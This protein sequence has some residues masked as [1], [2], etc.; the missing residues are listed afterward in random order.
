MD[1]QKK[2]EFDKAKEIFLSSQEV[3]NKGNFDEAERIIRSAMELIQDGSRESEILLSSCLN[4]LGRIYEERGQL[5]EGVDFHRKCLEKRRLLL[6]NDHPE[7]AFSLGNLGTGLAAMGNFVEAKDYLEEC[8]AS[9]ER[10]GVNNIQVEGWR[11]NLE[12]CYMAI[13]DGM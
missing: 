6:G 10:L 8:I 5:A 12:V 9:Y 11:R 7:T 3:Y 13:E 2:S 1:N 4:N